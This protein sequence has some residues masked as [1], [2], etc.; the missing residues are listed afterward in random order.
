MQNIDLAELA[1]VVGGMNTEGFR[2][3]TNIE[4]RR[5][6]SI[7]DSLKAPNTPGPAMPDLVRSPGDL[8]SQAGLDDIKL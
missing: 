3:S 7:E 4:D 5:D 8:S 2:R 6:M 1:G